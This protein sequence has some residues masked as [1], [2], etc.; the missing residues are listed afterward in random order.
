MLTKKDNKYI[1]YDPNNSSGEVTY[2]N[3]ESLV[4]GLSWSFDSYPLLTN[5]MALTVDI[6]ARSSSQTVVREMSEFYNY[7]SSEMSNQMTFNKK[8]MIVHY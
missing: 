5:Q 1:V 8:N 4:R 6:Y 2:A 7:F 3:E